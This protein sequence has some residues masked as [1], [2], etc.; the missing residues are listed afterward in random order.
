[1][2]TDRNLFRNH[3]NYKKAKYTLMYRKL[4]TGNYIRLFQKVRTV[5]IRKFWNLF[6]I[7]VVWSTRSSSSTLTGMGS[8]DFMLVIDITISFYHFQRE[9]ERE[10]RLVLFF[11]LLISFLPLFDPCTIFCS[12]IITRLLIS[13]NI[14]YLSVS[15]SVKK[16][17]SLLMEIKKNYDFWKLRQKNIGN[18][19][20]NEYKVR[21]S[22]YIVFWEH[23]AWGSHQHTV[24]SRGV[25]F[26]RWN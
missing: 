14:W 5:N 2:K 20:L 6:S 11:T 12:G 19:D 1:M 10:R 15:N 4:G 23:L 13:L 8:K 7:N 25:K 17:K 22:T 26:M 21:S 16:K 9:R 24:E 3:R 18:L